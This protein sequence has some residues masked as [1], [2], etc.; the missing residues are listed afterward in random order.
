MSSYRIVVAAN[1]VVLAL[2][3]LPRSWGEEVE[4]I[5]RYCRTQHG[6]ALFGIDLKGNGFRYAPDRQVDVL[7]IKLDVTPDFDKR[8]VSGTTTITFSPIA[9]PL[10]QLRLDA[11]DL[12]IHEV[13]SKTRVDDYVSSRTDLRIQFAE[14]I[15][16]GEKVDIEIDHEAQPT[17]GLYF[18]TPAMGYPKT[19]TQVWTQGE[20]H[21]ARYW[22]PCF[23]YPNERSTTEMICHVPFDMTVLSNGRLID[24]TTD[25]ATGLKTVHWLQE[26]PHVNYLI[27]LVAG[28]MKKLEKQHGEIP[29]AFYTQPTLLEHAANSFADTDKIMAFFEEEIGMP[30]PWSKYYQVTIRDFIAGGMEN[31]SL[32]TL[33]HRTIFSEATENIRT[34]RRLDAHEL[35]HQWF[36]DLVTCKDW[37]HLWLN[38]GFATYY[39]HL[40]EGSKFGRD[41]MLYGLY[42]DAKRSILTQDKDRKPIVYKAYTNARQ[43][44]D[45]RAYPKGS[46]VLHML[47]SQLGE[48]LY[49]QCIKT[50]LRRHAF[51]S[52]VTDDLRQVIEEQSGKSFDQFFDQWVYHARF[53]DLKVTYAWQPSSKLAKVTVEQTH[54]VDKDVL[55]FRFPTKLRFVVDGSAVDHDI[56]VTEKK[57][58]FFVPLAKKPEIVRF[59]PNLT[60]LAKITFDKTDDL[61]SAQLDNS[62]DMI[63]RILAVEALAKRKT[64]KSVERLKELLGSD[65]FFG[66]RIAAS[67]AL[68]KIHNDEAFAALTESLDQP[69]AR[70]RQQVV[71]DVGKF[72]REETLGHLQS[73]LN[74]EKNPAIAAAAIRAAGRFSGS[75]SQELITE[76]LFSDS[77]RNELA[78]AAISAIRMQNDASYRTLLIAALAKTQK[79]FTSRGFGAGLETLARISRNAE[80]ADKSETRDFISSHLNHP[81]EAIRIAAIRAL[82]VLRDSRSTS[83]LETLSDKERSDRVA[84]A[85]RK[86]LEE[87]Q[88]TTPIVPKEVADLRGEVTKLRSDNDRLKKDLEALKKQ[89]EAARPKEKKEKAATSEAAN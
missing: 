16:V 32:T 51:S 28:H 63:G 57:H 24:E 84:E 46:W 11:A 89:F 13:R 66:I 26:K 19:D 61:L 5:C 15:A 21:E 17:R 65:S 29:L 69:D 62:D 72:F 43:Q 37:S 58:D 64:H 77:F 55:Q 1:L 76:Q 74:S 36:G 83:V 7:H 59:D 39:T 31:T 80:D 25:P 48:E 33:T 85:A 79:S 41:A 50:Y 68:Q 53:P 8:T 2:C 44:F 82:G 87:I 54:K 6:S 14:P 34:T 22:F 81:K 9:K 45:Y 30:Y 23:D 3:C 18:R 12:T 20:A 38:E 73:I 88:K 42:R 70:V 27:C 4:Q 40:Y 75:Q 47:R 35:A 86:A 78:D 71:E 49:R 60:V 52:V 67:S 10:T 56:E